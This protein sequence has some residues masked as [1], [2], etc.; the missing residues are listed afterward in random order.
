VTE[1]ELRELFGKFGEIKSVFNLLEKRGL[2]FITFV[3][4]PNV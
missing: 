1:E 3:R 4:L 2:M